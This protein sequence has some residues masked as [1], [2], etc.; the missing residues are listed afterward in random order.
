M[1]DA[2]A[3][4]SPAH[5]FATIVPE[6]R[7]ALQRLLRA[8]FHA[9]KATEDERTALRSSEPPVSDALAQDY[10]AW[11]RSILWLA[12]VLMVASVVLALFSFQ[13][14]ESALVEG[15]IE[16]AEAAGHTATEDE[17]R[18][19][20]RRVWGTSN[21]ET[22]GTLQWLDLLIVVLSASFTILGVRSWR[23]VGAS[24]KWARRAACVWI[25][26]PVLMALIPWSGL[27]DFGHLP[28]E[29][30]RAMKASLGVILGIAMTMF[31][32][33][34][35][36][37]LFPGTIRSAILLK[38]LVPETGVPGWVIVICAPMYVIALVL[39]VSAITQV[40]GDALLVFGVIFLLLAPI[41]YLR[42]LPSL[43]RPLDTETAAKRMRAARRVAYVLN[44]LGGLLLLIFVFQMDMVGFW[45]VCKLLVVAGGGFLLLMV[46]GS[47]FMVRVVKVTHD[48]GTALYGSEAGSRL[49]ARLAA[50]S[51]EPRASPEADGTGS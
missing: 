13:T 30:A 9:I 38:T 37:S 5:F 17:A 12:S 20:V 24:H 47:D 16:N 22:L 35:L 45:D 19:A 51:M 41:S 1:S 31:V 28:A 40:Q 23:T 21:L 49:G 6:A 18:T 14:F 36:L 8:D 50:L 10:A 48:H 7:R 15:E 33:P 43:L 34:K 26:V 29:Q 42:Y 11:R 2:A 27:L 44:A 32:A 46:V 4:P 3:D 39:G 25:L